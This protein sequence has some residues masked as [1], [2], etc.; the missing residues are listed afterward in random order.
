LNAG[1]ALALLGALRS[2]NR[3]A[4]SGKMASEELPLRIG[5][6]PDA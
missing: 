5:V 2:E 3:A 4:R 1:A 6:F